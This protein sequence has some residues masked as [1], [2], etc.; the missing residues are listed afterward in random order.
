[1]AFSGAG[2]G[3]CELTAVAAA[4]EMAPTR[5]RGTYVALLDLSIIPF[6]PSVLWGQLI[7]QY[8]HWRFVGLLIGGWNGLGLLMTFFFYFPPPRINS[9]GLSRNEIISRIDYLGGF[10]SI[11]GVALVLVAIQFGGYQVGETGEGAEWTA[12]FIWTD[13]FVK[14][15]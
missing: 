14:T 10:L 8:S 1:M 6:V 12:H 7:T 3:I 2:A 13:A 15:V 9:R 5:K 11:S 4:S